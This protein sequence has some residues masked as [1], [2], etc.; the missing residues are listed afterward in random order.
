MLSFNEGKVCE[1]IVWHLEERAKSS[2]H[3][4]RWPEDEGHAH[5]VEVA[6][7]FGVDLFA[8]EHTG[9][10]PFKGHVRMEAEAERH[11]KPITEALK[12]ALGTS[13]VFELHMPADAFQG[14]RMVE[15]RTLQQA[16]ILWVTTTAPTCAPSSIL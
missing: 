11:F 15:I 10:E 2:R 4:V 13:A 14:R 9:I 5:P 1:A 6:F 8:L 16:I 7:S 3:G 12:N